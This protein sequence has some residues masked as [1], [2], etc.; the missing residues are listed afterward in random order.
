MKLLLLQLALTLIKSDE[1]FF[2]K[3]KLHEL[4]LMNDYHL[5][6]A[7]ETQDAIHKL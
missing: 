6:A 1:F 7:R 4:Q 2:A 3:D 5:R